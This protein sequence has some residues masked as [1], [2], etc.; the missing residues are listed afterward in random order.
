[1]GF[2]INRFDEWQMWGPV[3][4]YEEASSVFEE[5]FSLEL[6]TPG[7]HE[8][9]INVSH[10]QKRPLKLELHWTEI[11]LTIVIAKTIKEKLE[12]DNHQKI[13][14]WHNLPM[15]RNEAKF[16]KTLL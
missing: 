12:S 4:T 13:I 1:M 6:L 2:L 15:G 11:D 8:K 5:S 16:K 9:T 14:S 7:P 10:K 3:I